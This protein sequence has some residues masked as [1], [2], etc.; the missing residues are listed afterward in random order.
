MY[1]V[2]IKKITEVHRRNLD[3]G[4]YKAFP[5][6]LSNNQSNDVES[7]MEKS[8]LIDIQSS[9]KTK[10][11]L[12]FALGIERNY[13]NEFIS[14]D[15]FNNQNPGNNFFPTFMVN[16]DSLMGVIDSKYLNQDVKVFNI[17]RKYKNIDTSNILM[18]H[19]FD[20]ETKENYFYECIYKKDIDN[21][22]KMKILFKTVSYIDD[23]LSTYA[24]VDKISV[25]KGE[26][27]KMIIQYNR[28]KPIPLHYGRCKYKTKRSNL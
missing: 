5:I 22:E 13:L 10:E 6:N 7:Y 19:R 14:H 2:D 26:L 1:N 3:Q 25:I 8:G 21:N 16:C 20:A 28:K 27:N 11:G 18:F 24:A 9:I 4:S 17:Q 23:L 12:F 15:L